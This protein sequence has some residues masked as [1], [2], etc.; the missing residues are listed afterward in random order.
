MRETNEYGFF[1]I[2]ARSVENSRSFVGDA[3]ED[4]RV[5]ETASSYKQFLFVLFFRAIKYKYNPLTLDKD[6]LN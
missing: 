2:R 4:E 1:I 3:F 6:A 5:P